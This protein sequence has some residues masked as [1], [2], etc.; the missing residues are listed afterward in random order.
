M[1][2]STT[3]SSAPLSRPQTWDRI[4]PRLRALPGLLIKSCIREYSIWVSFTRSPFLVS[5]RLWVF[6]KK[7]PCRS[8]SLSGPSASAPV[9]RNRA[10]MR[11]VS[12]A[13]EKGL[14]T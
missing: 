1:F 4:S 10:S 5:T 6:S 8:S 11:A 13:V 2:T 14:V 12:S 9:R 7:G 3:F